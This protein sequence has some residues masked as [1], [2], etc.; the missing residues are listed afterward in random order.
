MGRNKKQFRFLF[1]LAF[2]ALAILAAVFLIQ[3]F[4]YFSY[5]FDISWIEDSAAAGNWTTSLTDSYNEVFESRNAF[6][7]SSV[8]GN[9]LYHCGSSTFGK[10]VRLVIIIMVFLLEI[11][12]VRLSFAIIKYY[13]KRIGHRNQRTRSAVSCRHY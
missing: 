3:S 10:L 7:S 2:I 1:F 9:L 12:F 13:S 6:I 8:I 4:R 5:S 11:M